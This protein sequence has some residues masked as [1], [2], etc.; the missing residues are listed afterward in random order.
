MGSATSGLSSVRSRRWRRRSGRPASPRSA[1]GRSGRFAIISTRQRGGQSRP[2]AAGAEARHRRREDQ[3]RGD[4]HRLA[5]I[6]AVR[7]P[8]SRK[9]TRGF[10]V[11]T[12]GVTIRD[13]LR[14]LQ[15]NDPGSYHASR[16]LV[17][18]EM[19]RDL[20][21]A[22]IVVTNYHAFLR[23]E[24]LPP[25]RGGRALLQGPGPELRTKET[26]G[27]MLQRV[28]P[29][30]MGMK[31]I[32]ALND[33]AHHCYREKPAGEGEEGRS[34]ATTARRLSGTARGRGSGSPGS[35]RC[36]GSSACSASSTCRPRRSSCAGRVTARERCSPG[37][38]ATSR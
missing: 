11:V 18:N 23:R 16:E 36:S 24:T 25:S 30:L 2:R 22:K 33:E 20:E 26:E 34:R 21:R 15:P 35:R 9:F 17:P 12:P 14:V 10:L 3:R 19:L 8:G 5:D 28:M 7:R 38:Q 31:R 4:A 29:G 32:L 37:R 1:A 13:R 6:N 27:Q